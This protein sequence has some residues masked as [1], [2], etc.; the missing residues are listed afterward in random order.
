MRP[1]ALAGL[2]ALAACTK[3]THITIDPK[4]PQLKGHKETV[5]LIAHVMTNSVEDAKARVQWRSENPEI[6]A[7][8]E[9]GKVSGKSSGRTELVATYGDLKASV[10]IEV[11]WVEQV[12]A[13]KGVVE[14]SYQEGDAAK[15]KVEAVGFDGRVL[16]DRP[17]SW[18]SETENVC[19][20]DPSG[21]IWPTG[22][23]EGDVVA[24]FDE[25]HSIRIHCVVKK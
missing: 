2:L 8:D 14:L 10:P 15:V 4:Q 16:K 3:P 1:L 11:S 5:Q 7:V 24:S 25:Q 6:A 18:K 13:D 17:I 12:R 9:S 19:R 21:Q 22:V 23:G 20:A